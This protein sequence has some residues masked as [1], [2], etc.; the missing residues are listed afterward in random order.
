MEAM[1]IQISEKERYRIENMENK[2]KNRKRATA[3]F[4]MFCGLN[5][6]G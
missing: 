2:G 4:S 1:V 5:L 6:S 3:W